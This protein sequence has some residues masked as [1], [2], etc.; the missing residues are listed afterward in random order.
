MTGPR[1]YPDNTAVSRTPRPTK[2]LG[3]LLKKILYDNPKANIASLRD[4]VDPATIDE[5]LMQAAMGSVG[6]MDKVGGKVGEGLRKM[7]GISGKKPLVQ[8]GMEGIE[9]WH[10]SPYRG[11]EKF[12]LSKVGT[13]M[14]QQAYGH[15]LYFAEN[16]I[17]AKSYRNVKGF[18]IDGEPVERSRA[19]GAKELA[20]AA[21]DRYSNK[22]EAINWIGQNF[23][24]TG[25]E[26]KKIIQSAKSW[27]PDNGALYRT[28]L[29]VDPDE[30]LD[31]A[32]PLAQQPK[33]MGRLDPEAMGLRM[34][35]LP[36]GYR[37]FV[38]AQNQPLGQLARGGTA[39]SFLDRWMGS[40]KNADSGEQAY[41]ALSNRSASS[42]ALKAAGVP[43]IKYR[44]GS[45]RN[46]VMFD[47]ER[48]KILEMLGLAGVGAL[49]AKKGN[50]AR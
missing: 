26:A 1:I 36:S 7:L 10:G 19:Y 34:S 43:G 6:S 23:P 30:M 13:G 44:D 32:K 14:G 20:A 35:E 5:F 42:A 8:A 17:V 4:P 46:Y 49:G 25:P 39:D 29:E 16:P 37:A 11:I 45:S 38:N 47:P 9:A 22:A 15:G 33:V 2:G 48:I 18:Q 12:D 24:F 31:W 50:E 21:L 28:R 27:G 3:D 41:R 40:L